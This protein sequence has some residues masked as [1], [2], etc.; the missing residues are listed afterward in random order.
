[1]Y[2]F[3]PTAVLKIGE[4]TQ[5]HEACFQLGPIVPPKDKFRITGVHPIPELESSYVTL[6][7]VTNT[8]IRLYFTTDPFYHNQ[9][10]PPFTE[11]PLANLIRPTNFPQRGPDSVDSMW[12]RFTAIKN[13]TVP[14]NVDPLAQTRHIKG[15]FRLLLVRP[16]PAGFVSTQDQPGASYA[17]FGVW[18][19]PGTVSMP[20]A[21]TGRDGTQ[22][23]S[24]RDVVKD[25]DRR[26]TLASDDVVHS[27][28]A[29][30]T[31]DAANAIKVRSVSAIYITS[32]VVH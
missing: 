7:V 26:Y 30:T 12:T 27:A 22:D 1:M 14:R 17:N 15:C 8:G 16:P 29:F 24:R 13:Y 4:Y 10:R 19:A 32:Y 6:L 11:N 2:Y 28:V 23:W 3:S 21:S 9:H 25:L 31:V 5:C 18:A 20:R